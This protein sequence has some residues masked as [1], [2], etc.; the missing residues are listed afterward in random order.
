MKITSFP[1]TARI[2][3]V[4]MCKNAWKRILVCVM[5]VRNMKKILLL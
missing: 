5:L 1:Q 3:Y 4:N 2:S